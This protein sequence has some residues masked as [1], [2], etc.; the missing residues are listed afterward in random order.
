MVNRRPKWC[1]GL[2][3]YVRATALSGIFPAGQAQTATTLVAT[4]SSLPEPLYVAWGDA[5]H[6]KHPE[7][8]LRYLP[9]G[10]AESASKILA[11][12][13]PLGGGDEPIPESGGKSAARA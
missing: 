7:T 1:E 10:T 4:R 11:R 3:C 5:Y 13:G 12:V 9:E 6:A 2:A 8:Q